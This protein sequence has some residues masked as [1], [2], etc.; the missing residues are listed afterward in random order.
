MNITQEIIAYIE[1]ACLQHQKL[2]IH[3]TLKIITAYREITN[4]PE[5]ID[6]VIH[7]IKMYSKQEQFSS[8]LSS[9]QN[10]IFNLIGLDFSS[11]EIADMLS[12]S[13]ATVS[14]H[15]KNII[16]KLQISGAGALQRMAYQH[17]QERHVV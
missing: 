13:E 6:K 17:I 16:R 11:K 10:Q 3:Q 12:I 1:R 9:R 5:L 7:L 15:R 4:H 14:T 2:N 8:L